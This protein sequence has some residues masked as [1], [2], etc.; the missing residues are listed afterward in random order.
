MSGNKTPP[1]VVWDTSVFLA[2]FK[3]E[4]AKPLHLVAASAREIMTNRV[5]LLVSA[6]TRIEIMNR[7]QSPGARDKFKQF[8]KRSNVSLVMPDERIIDLAL[9]IRQ[10]SADENA[11]CQTNHPVLGTCDSIIAATAIIYKVPRLFAF[12]SKLKK[13]STLPVLRG[14]NVTDPE[15]L[16]PVLK[17]H[18]ENPN[19]PG[20]FD[21]QEEET[22]EPTVPGDDAGAGDLSG[23][24]HEADSQDGGED[25]EADTEEGEETDANPRG[26]VDGGDGEAI[27]PPDSHGIVEGSQTMAAINAILEKEDAADENGAPGVRDGLPVAVPATATVPVDAHPKPELPETVTTTTHA[28]TVGVAEK[29]DQPPASPPATGSAEK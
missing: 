12:D 20:L 24:E 9:E 23:P 11:A 21:G 27:A 4:Q 14:L 10:H 13:Y 16:S 19:Q 7:P 28:A 18:P 8:L 5:I 25:R 29:S 3:R 22:G 26:E 2:W 17:P 15:E 1:A 6:V